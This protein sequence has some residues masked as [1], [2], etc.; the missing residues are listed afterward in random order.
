MKKLNARIK[1]IQVGALVKCPSESTFGLGIVTEVDLDMWGHAQEPPGI[2]VFWHTP[3][4]HD[5]SDGASVMYAD[6]IEVI[7][8]GRR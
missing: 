7:N 3:T 8:E 6:E 4:W 1:N 2:K 5:P